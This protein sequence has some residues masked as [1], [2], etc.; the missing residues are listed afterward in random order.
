MGYNI[1]GIIINSLPTFKENESF[2]SKKL[3]TKFS[4]TRIKGLAPKNL[5]IGFKDNN[6]A[7][8]LDLIFYKN[9]SEDAALTELETD[10]DSIF[11]N[12]RILIIAI[13]DTV[14][15]AGYSLIENGI[16]LRTKAVVNDQIFLDFGELEA[17]EI[18]LYI[19]A[20]KLA[21]AYP[22]IIQKIDDLYAGQPELSKKKQYIKWRDAFL[23]KNSKENYDYYIDGS[24][25][26][27]MIEKEFQRLLNC[28]YNDLEQ[29]DFIEFDRRKLNF[30][31]DS[32][33]EY[34]FIASKQF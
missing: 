5:S 19:H 24:L 27:I 32:L 22:S 7:I 13:N 11:P 20:Q 14:N 21:K 6:T 26:S 25:D 3:K 30:K 8:F 4:K 23:R 29:L 1:C 17:R 31:K 34:L 15:F 10:L 18:L 12:S 9:I 16:K 28:D 2:D 33:R